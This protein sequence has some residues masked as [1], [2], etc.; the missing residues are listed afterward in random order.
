M[1]NPQLH[2]FNNFGT[3]FVPVCPF[4]LVSVGILKYIFCSPYCFCFIQIFPCRIKAFLFRLPEDFICTAYTCAVSNREWR[5]QSCDVEADP[6]VS[7]SWKPGAH[8]EAIWP[9]NG[10]WHPAKECR[11]RLNL[12][13][14]FLILR[15]KVKHFVKVKRCQYKLFCHR[16]TTILSGV[17]QFLQCC[18]PYPVVKSVF[19][20]GFEIRIR[21]QDGKNYPQK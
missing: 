2:F 5:S 18:A 10:R 17:P 9:A 11:V 20:S 1:Q 7:Y 4:C 3:Y 6:A 16:S 15:Y 14:L 21:I 13:R 19:G 12:Y 8:C